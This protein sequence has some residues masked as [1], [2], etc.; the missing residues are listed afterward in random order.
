MP[1]KT[2]N[3]IYDKYIIK[4]NKEKKSV[5]LI[6]KVNNDTYIDVILIYLIMK[7]LN[8]FLY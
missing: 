4:G 3:K 1:D 7:I 8:N 5:S 6:F 2:I